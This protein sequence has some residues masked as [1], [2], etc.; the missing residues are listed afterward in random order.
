[1]S[2]GEREVERQAAAEEVGEQ[3]VRAEEAPQVITCGMATADAE[4]GDREVVA[5]QAQHD[6]ADQRQPPAR[7]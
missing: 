5:A 6:Q 3:A 2:C 4:R 7:R 1:M